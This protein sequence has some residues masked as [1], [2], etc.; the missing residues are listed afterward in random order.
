MRDPFPMRRATA[1]TLLCACVAE[2]TYNYT[3]PDAST[4]PQ[5]RPEQTTGTRPPPPPAEGDEDDDAGDGIGFINGAEMGS[6][7]L[8]CNLWEQDC[9]DD[10]KCMPWANDGG[11]IWNATRCTPLDPNPAD[12]GE[13]C[14]VEERLASGIDNCKRH[15]MCL[16]VDSETLEGACIGLCT[17]SPSDPSCEND[18]EEC[19]LPDE[20]SLPLCFPPC[21]PLEQDCAPGYVCVPRGFG[22]SCGLLAAEGG[23]RDPCN[24]PNDCAPGLFCAFGAA[25]PGCEDTAACCERFCDLNEPAAIQCTGYPVEDCVPW[26]DWGQGLPSQYENVGACVI[27]EEWALGPGGRVPV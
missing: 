8:E 6:V 24:S 5:S 23:Y 22:F 2:G 3:P 18:L 16:Y 11:N 15:A 10:E 7:N 21:H 25:V 1:F 20:S 12:V 4:G 17:G 9:P 26:R 14:T 27:P 19:W 13:P